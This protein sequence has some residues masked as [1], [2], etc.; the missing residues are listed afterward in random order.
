MSGSRA[1]LKQA[2]KNKN[3]QTEERDRGKKEKVKK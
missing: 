2:T 1:I 3:A